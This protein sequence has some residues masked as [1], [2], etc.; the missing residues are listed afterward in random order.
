MVRLAA[1]VLDSF[2]EYIASYCNVYEGF[3][4]RMWDRYVP[5]SPQVEATAS[6]LR[7]LLKVTYLPR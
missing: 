5:F 2:H 3:V 6:S 1:Y 4:G 7:S